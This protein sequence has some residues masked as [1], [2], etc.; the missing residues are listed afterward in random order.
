[1]LENIVSFASN[2]STNV[3]ST[4]TS[5][6]P[7]VSLLFSSVESFLFPFL[8][9]FAIVYGVLQRSEIFKGKSDIDAIIAFVLGIIF[10]TTNYTL[11]L[12]Y[13]IL[14][15]VGIIAIVVFMV[16]VIGSMLYGS[17]SELLKAKSARKII[18]VIAVL[19]SIGLIIWV[20][21][22][23][24]L[25]FVGLSTKSVAQNLSTYAPYIIVFIAL[26][27][28]AYFLFK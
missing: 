20:L 17:S 11:K 6:A 15:I 25:G 27:I 21:L 19:V 18:V 22:T 14:P 26:I 28:G 13:L 4:L 3:T 9:V 5:Q 8:L 10:A 2:N 1:M 7:G 24:N 23:A 16:M 12:T